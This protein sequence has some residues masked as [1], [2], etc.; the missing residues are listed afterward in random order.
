VLVADLLAEQNHDRSDQHARR[1]GAAEFGVVAIR[2]GRESGPLDTAALYGVGCVARV[3]QVSE[4]PGGRYDLVTTG[5][6]R[7]R[8]LDVGAPAPY[9]SAE[10]D[11]LDDPVGD[12][13]AELTERVHAGFL[14][15]LDLVTDGVTDELVANVPEEPRALS[16]LVAATMAISLPDRQRL[17]EAADA[18][19]RLVAEHDLLGREI[20]LIRSLGGLPATD[21]TRV[22][23]SPN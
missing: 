9:L 17:L 19:T 15:Y 14:R 2:H 16:Y 1:F 20:Q 3:R 13:S 10:V 5:T 23:Y 18:A 8:V 12:A 7:F 21:L 11:R 6:Q 4:V 22:G